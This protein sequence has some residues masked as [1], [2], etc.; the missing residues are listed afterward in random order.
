YAPPTA[1][2][3][4]VLWRAKD[5]VSTGVRCRVLVYNA[6][7]KQ[8]PIVLEDLLLPRFKGKIGIS[9]ALF[10]TGSD[11]AASL[12][13]RR[14]QEN[15]LSYF[16]RLKANG[17]QILPGNSV[18]AERVGR[19]ELL[20]GVT[21]TDDFLALQK[22]FPSLRISLPTNNRLPNDLLF[23]PMTAA[24]IKNAPHMNNAKKLMD[25]LSSVQ[26]EAK[27]VRAMP[28][29]LPLRAPWNDVPASIAPLKNYIGSSRNDLEKWG[30]S[31]Q[32]I[33]EPLSDILLRD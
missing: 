7:E 3:L 6:R 27:I 21:D 8:P 4:P 11:W 17:A 5:W 23:I 29:V 9:N 31:W 22:Q 30:V 33:R 2:S 15:A 10:G 12:A 19:G 24:I 26:T 28:G 1:Q 13:S 16:R 18:V 32:K 20:A 14:G 25:A